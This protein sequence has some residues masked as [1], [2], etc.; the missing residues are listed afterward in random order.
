MASPRRDTEIAET[1]LDDLQSEFEAGSRTL[2]SI[3][4]RARRMR[5]SLIERN[6][7]QAALA[8]S[9]MR[10][11]SELQKSVE[12]QRERLAELRSNL[13]GVSSGRARHP[14]AERRWRDASTRAQPRT[15]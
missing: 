3:A 14:A 8:G 5:E 4:A 11:I 1:F 12:Q 13:P 10:K 6:L 9:L 15:D 2:K 7:K